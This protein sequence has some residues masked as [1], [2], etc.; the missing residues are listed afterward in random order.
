MSYRLT[1]ALGGFAVL[2]S[3]PFAAA[4][5]DEAR[6][7]K[8]KDVREAAEKAGRDPATLTITVFGA[9][10]DA[11]AL[12]PPSGVRISD[13]DLGNVSVACSHR[14]PR[15]RAYDLLAR[16]ERGDLTRRTP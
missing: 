16:R 5:I 9:P 15:T 7:S 4:A 8:K 2:A 13:A 10:P 14:S 11:A 6:K 12:P 3:R 1:L